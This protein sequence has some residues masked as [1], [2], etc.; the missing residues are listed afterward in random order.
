ME[1]EGKITILSSEEGV[2]IEIRD[3]NSSIRF[4]RIFLTPEQF[5]EAIGRTANVQCK[6]ILV[7]DLDKIGKTM[8][9]KTMEFEIGEIIDRDKLKV[10]SQEILDKEQSGWISDGYFGSYNS[11]FKKGDKNFARCT[12]RR[13]V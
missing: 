1:I 12:I 13:W 11:F 8:E 4:C 3:S 5:T 10:L 6:S 9:N 7:N 2:S